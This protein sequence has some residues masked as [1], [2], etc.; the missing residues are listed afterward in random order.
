MRQTSTNR[1]I[2]KRN[3]LRVWT[4]GTRLKLILLTGVMTLG[5]DSDTP[6]ELTHQ[7]P[8]ESRDTTPLARSYAQRVGT[9][10]DRLEPGSIARVSAQ[11]LQLPAI[12]NADAI[13][14]ALGVDDRGHIWV[15]ISAR[16]SANAHLVEYDPQADAFHA[17]GDPL[18]ALMQEKMYR[19]G[20]LQGKIHTHI[21]QA[22]DGFLYFAS[23]D[24]TDENWRE[25]R[26]PRWGSHVWRID[27]MSGHWQHVF[28]APEGLIALS[29]VGR[30]VYALGYWNHIIY[31][32]DTSTQTMRSKVIGSA[33]GHVSR[34]L[35]ADLRGHVYVPRISAVSDPGAACSPDNYR[36]H[37][38]ELDPTLT[39]IGQHPLD[40]Y[41]GE[42]RLSANKGITAYA[43]RRDNSLLF[44]TD[45]GKIFHLIV[46]GDGPALVM[47][48]GS[49]M[50][51]EESS[52]HGLFSPDGAN[53][54]AAAARTKNTWSWMRH[55]T[56]IMSHDTVDLALPPHQALL[57]YGSMTRDQSGAYYLG[58]RM[59]SAEQLQAILLK[60][61]EHR[62]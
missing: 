31:Q 8:P 45:T 21:Q 55:D 56:V 5:C 43:F 17:R 54:V 19:D 48:L 60:I 49:M 14:G 38:I 51:K 12:A 62:Q 30:Y 11:R 53:T 13:W 27:P 57:L 6:T 23:M 29:A 4:F 10:F 41:V 61:T 18:N 7:V 28:A 25:G 37:L 26:L 24:E 52:T 2:E 46:I 16:G 58:G 47:N 40:D 42:R 33:C 44:V 59:K 1:F 32:Y 50:V 15:G 39:P 34:N 36:A 35:L 3:P 9:V 20:E 22:D